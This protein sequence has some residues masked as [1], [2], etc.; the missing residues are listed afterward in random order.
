M[1]WHPR[2]YLVLCL[3]FALTLSVSPR[4]SGQTVI[5]VPAGGNLQQAIDQA[6]PG[7]TITLE[8]GSSYSGQFRLRQKTGNSFITITTAGSDVI[9]PPDIRITPDDAV[10][11]A[12]IISPDDGP[13]IVTDDGAHHYRLVGLEVTV[14]DGIYSL[15]LISLGS[16][17]ATNPAQLASDI[18]LDR[19]YI[20]PDANRGG[21]RGVTLN[22]AA[23]VVK[24]C[25]ISDFKS[26]WQD[27][28][29]IIGWNGPGPFTITN[30]Y[31]EASGQTL[32]FGAAT[33]KIDGLIASDI[34][35]ARNYIRKPPAWK[36]AGYSVR[37]M[38]DLKV[39]R[40]VLVEGNVFENNWTGGDPQGFP[41]AFT[42]RTQRG[43]IPWA[44]VEDITFVKN[45]V[46]NT[47]A[48]VTIL[49]KDYNAGGI[50]VARRILVKDNLFYGVD[51]GQWGADGRL[52]QIAAG[53]E[54]VTIDHNTALQLSTGKYLISF[55]G[56]PATRFTF[57][58]N[59]GQHG[60]LGVAGTGQGTGIPTLNSFA[61]GYLFQSNALIGGNPS[62]YPGGN[63]FPADLAAVGFTDAAN[64][65]YLLQANSPYRNSGTDGKDLGADFGALLAATEGVT[66]T[67]SQSPQTPSGA[68]V[69]PA[70]GQGSPQ[71]FRV[72][73]SDGNG[74]SDIGWT[75]VLVNDAIAQTGGCY[76]QFRP[77]L[78]SLWLRADNGASWLG[79]VTLGSGNNL[80][81]S[82]CTVNAGGSSAS[83]LGTDVTLDLR[84][85]FAPGFMG[86]RNVY[87]FAADFSGRVSGWQLRGSWTPF[88]HLPPAVASVMPSSGAAA[89]QTFRA[90]YS[91]P[92]GGDDV[93][94]AYVLFHTSVVQTDACYI[95]YS[96]ALNQLWLRNDA[97]TLWLGP[98]S[99]GSSAPLAN[100]QCSINAQIS[101]A[102]ASG[103]SLTLDL[104]FTLEPEFK[105]K[106]NVY[107]LAADRIGNASAWTKV[108]TWDV[109][110]R[111]P[112]VNS[113]T[114][115]GYGSANAFQFVFMDPDGASD[116]KATY[117]VLNKE[118][119][120]ASA[121]YIYFK[122]G[123]NEIYLR[124]D[125]G[126]A[127]IGP[128]VVGDP[129]TLRN[130]Q[131]TLDASVSSTS[132]SG[133]SRVLNIGIV[134]GIG[135][136]GQKK[137][138]LLAIDQSNASSDW[139]QRGTW[140]VPG[141]AS[142]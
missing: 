135:F 97:G 51:H 15:E 22:S 71:T 69:S 14:P 137:I 103:A 141:P 76:V 83:R 55:D 28:Q 90:L 127:W 140:L 95:R 2:P 57:K 77:T 7:D 6:Q 101:S 32:A 30:N 123:P 19:L 134:F 44:V 64:D 5:H 45:I 74:F 73:F 67:Q 58:N 34:A 86:Q 26:T 119:S 70:S 117:V 133:T 116:L 40:R 107:G 131:C 37:N 129:S 122:P 36:S 33:P 20:H 53:P 121:C 106:K 93:A 25:W 91:D 75:Y 112:T 50:G 88:A 80:S 61:P 139:Q 92:N 96:Q 105:G 8:A 72:V 126:T 42:V 115:S 63:H 29:A 128:A 31:L 68:S 12:K 49:G 79:P 24:N 87:L 132:T 84:L 78:N 66:D 59:I 4:S 124:N 48:G 111:P 27:T 85:T 120:G 54:D 109:P 100:G 98:V 56:D 142:N 11:V 136:G 114:P 108:G 113:L 39:A 118:L 43:A 104:A 110:G 13:A 125:A 94:W 35:I 89:T 60:A 46:R 62:D 65:D 17:T 41:I 81:N 82:Q 38:L 99:I 18:E 3:A 52:F 16:A 138:Y 47:P 102:Q 21:K 9:P 10:A 130:K 1:R 23:T